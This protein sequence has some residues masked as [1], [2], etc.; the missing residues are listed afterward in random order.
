M[1]DIKVT[2][3]AGYVTNVATTGDLVDS[4]QVQVNDFDM[5]NF[6]CYKLVNGELV[7]DDEKH[8]AKINPPLNLLKELKTSELNN[9]CNKEPV[10]RFYC[11]HCFWCVF[12][13]FNRGFLFFWKNYKK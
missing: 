6:D 4:V 10:L 3:D 7:W 9:V 1:A 11:M 13:R 5:L 8:Q 12:R 2:V